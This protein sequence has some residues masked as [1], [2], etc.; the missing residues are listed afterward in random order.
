MTSEIILDINDGKATA[1]HDFGLPR[2]AAAMIVYL[3]AAGPSEVMQISRGARLQQPLVSNAATYLRRRGWIDMQT[4]LNA[5]PGR[6]RYV[7]SAKVNMRVIAE[8]L[9]EEEDRRHKE[10]IEK[11]DRLVI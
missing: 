2:H 9:R 8:E 5:R 4:M 3:L 7:Y 11:L 6:N 1:L 10:A